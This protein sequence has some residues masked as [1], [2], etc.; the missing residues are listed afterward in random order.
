[1]PFDISASERK[2]TMEENIRSYSSTAHVTHK[3][4]ISKK[5][6]IV[7]AVTVT[8]LIIAGAL[9]NHHHRHQKWLEYMDKY[10]YPFIEKYD[11]QDYEQ[12]AASTEAEL[13]Y[14]YK[15][16]AIDFFVFK[17][18]EDE[19]SFKVRLLSDRVGAPNACMK[20]QDGELICDYDFITEVDADGEWEYYMCLNYYKTALKV[21]S[22]MADGGSLGA[23][24][25]TISEDGSFKDEETSPLS[26]DDR[27]V[28]EELRPQ[29]KELYNEM[30]YVILEGI[31]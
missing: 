27:R 7:T 28:L 20:T 21:G 1:M 23:I 15:G 11:V 29:I 9:I 8:V 10:Y 25:F 6:V 17:P 2:N 26:A 30:R 19:F 18:R 22:D 3:R 24:S 16:D 5:Q 31:A 14:I 12:K 4:R 13:E